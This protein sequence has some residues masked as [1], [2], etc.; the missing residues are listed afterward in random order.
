MDRLTDLLNDRLYSCTSVYPC[1]MPLFP[2]VNHCTPF[3]QLFWLP[4]RLTGLC[5][6]RKPIFTQKI[7]FPKI[8]YKIVQYFNL[9]C[10]HNILFCPLPVL[11]YFSCPF[12]FPVLGPFTVFIF[13]LG[14]CKK[15]GV[16]YGL[17]L[18]MDLDEL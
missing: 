2:P 10:A 1:I 9:V 15:L 6:A 11:N 17:S 4:W 3:D 12:L 7:D 8:M 18:Q 16:Y 5:F 13:F 14:C